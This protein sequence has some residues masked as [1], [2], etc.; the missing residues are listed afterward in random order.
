MTSEISRPDVW[1]LLDLE[2]GP[3][4][5]P[6]LSVREAQATVM[7]LEWAASRSGEAMGDAA[8]TLATRLSMRLAAEG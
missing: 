2:F 4:R 6:L 8:Q 1:S 5:P 3:E 7:L